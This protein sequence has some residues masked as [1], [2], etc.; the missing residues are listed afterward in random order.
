MYIGFA[1]SGTDNA[2]YNKKFTT[3]VKKILTEQAKQVGLYGGDMRTILDNNPYYDYTNN[4]K[5]YIFM[6]LK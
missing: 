1:I 5:K 3:A 2:A 6:R 4:N